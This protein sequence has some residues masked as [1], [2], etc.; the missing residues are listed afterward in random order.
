MSWVRI[1]SLTPIWKFQG[2][3]AQL[4]EQLTLNQLVVGSNPTR[5]TN[6][7]RRS[8]NRAPVF[9]PLPL[10]QE[11]EGAKAVLTGSIIVRERGGVL[12]LPRRATVKCPAL[13]QGNHRLSGAGRLGRFPF[14]IRR[15][16]LRARCE[17]GGTGRRTRFRFWRVTPVRVRVPPFAPF[18]YQFLQ[19]RP[20]RR[21]IT[22][23]T[24]SRHAVFG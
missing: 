20:A 17:S 14:G 7:D 18:P 8:G 13:A 15:F 21:P 22:R 10:C 2:P 1:P 3:L 5:P 11:G 6:T 24:R 4:V 12:V 16:G 9:L 23:V 19:G